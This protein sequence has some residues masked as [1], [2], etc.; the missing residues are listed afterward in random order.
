MLFWGVSAVVVGLCS[1]L[2]LRPMMR[3]DATQFDESDAEVYRDQLKEI[4]RDVAR[5]LL[6][7]AEAETTRAEVGRRLLA[8]AE[9][10]TTISAGA[11]RRATTLGLIL[12]LVTLVVGTLA[13]YTGSETVLSGA[14]L[15]DTDI[16]DLKN[17]TSVDLPIGE[18]AVRI[19]PI[20]AGIGSPGMPDMPLAN[21]DFRAE[22]PTQEDIE[23]QFAAENKLE[24]ATPSVR[25][26]ALLDQLSE[27]LEERPDDATGFR[28]LANAQASLGRY[29]A[30]WRAQERVVDIK[31]DDV[32]G[33]ELTTLAELMIFAAR[34]YVSPTTEDI[35]ARALTVDP[36][37][38]RARY[39]SGAALAQNGEPELALRF[40]GGLLEEGPADAPWKDPVRQ[41]V[42]KLAQDTG[43]QLPEGMLAGPTQE[44][45]E[46]AQEMSEEDQQAMIRGMVEGLASR[47]AE[48][49][50]PP[51]EWARLISAL[52][53]LGES[54][55]ALAIAGE[56]RS[57]FSA[58]PDAVELINRAAAGIQ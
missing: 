34:G 5:G 43:V 25:D 37:D 57:V 12:V 4:E 31:G 35:L 9:R 32:S 15:E 53:V 23:Q 24:E 40:W 58:S 46:A 28:L 55:R 44:Q 6:N 14:G 30:A 51:E 38:R 27:K 16:A 39:Y 36:T 56:A 18:G 10:K 11:P 2:I 13:I 49:G 3:Q 52:G 19:G 1:W 48:D 50:G 41:Q 29:G 33:E 26:Q 22:R 42:R 54:E 17:R 20:F 47:L 21:R 45:I 7:D 8:A